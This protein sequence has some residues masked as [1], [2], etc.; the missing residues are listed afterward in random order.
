SAG[1]GQDTVRISANRDSNTLLIQAPQAQWIQIQRILGEID[2][3]PDQV[4]I[5]ASILEVT[6]SKNLQAGI[7]WSTLGA[8]GKLSVA[9]VNNTS[10]AVASTFPGLAVTFL[11]KDISAAIHALNAETAVE[12]VSAPKIMTLDNRPAHLQVGDQVPTVSQTSIGTGAP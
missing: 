12:V 3:E 9:S 1:S 8:G 10:G 5:E 4:L 11:D 2:R 7:D 6:L